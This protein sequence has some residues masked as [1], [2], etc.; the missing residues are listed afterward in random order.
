MLE[1]V[2]YAVMFI[3]DLLRQRALPED[4]AM[5]FEQNL[6]VLLDMQCSSSWYP[7][8]PHR[9]SGNRCIRVERGQIDPS[10]IQAAR[11]SGIHPYQLYSLFPNDIS[12]WIDPKSVCY[13]SVNSPLFSIYNEEDA[14]S[15]G[16][17][18]SSDGSETSRKSAG[19]LKRVEATYF[20]LV[21]ALEA[22]A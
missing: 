16:G 6:S 3:G 11:L 21:S 7:Q 15:S 2:N 19:S 13:K 4:L 18:F 10:I 17:G 12:I 22:C 8:Q 14:M 5:R 20:S 1:E 9:G